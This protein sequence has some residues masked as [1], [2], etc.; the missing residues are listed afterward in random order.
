MISTP[1]RVLGKAKDLYVRSMTRCGQTPSFAPPPSDMPRSFSVASSRSS[2]DGG[3]DF[4]ELIRAASARTL[5]HSF[6]KDLL[7]QLKAQHAAM[8]EEAAAAKGVVPRSC[9]AGMARIDEDAPCERF[10][11]GGEVEVEASHAAVS[12]GRKMKRNNLVYP[13]SRSYAVPKA[14]AL[15]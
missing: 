9:S 15:I 11:E 3:D 12:T 14:S 8:A 13:R 1:I 7:Q 4:R 2:A 10:D 6:E 5:G